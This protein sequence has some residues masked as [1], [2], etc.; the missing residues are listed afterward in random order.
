VRDSKSGDL[1]VKIV[2]GAGSAA[3]LGVQLAGM[4]SGDYK[5]VKTVLGGGD[6]D[7]VNEDGKPPVVK[8]ETSE[9]TVKPSFDYE[10]PANSLT[11]FRIKK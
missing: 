11:I 2:N 1:I 5:T 7:A 6:A 3:P 10:A 9:L 4:P 8:P